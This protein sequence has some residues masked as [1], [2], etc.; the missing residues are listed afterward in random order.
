M[1]SSNSS[2]WHRTYLIQYTIYIFSTVNL[3]FLAQHI[4][5]VALKSH[6][7]TTLYFQVASIY[8]SPT[9]G[10][11]I[12]IEIVKMEILHN[13]RV[14]KSIIMYEVTIRYLKAYFYFSL[15]F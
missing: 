10:N 7:F 15:R 14:S 11:A 2:L 9:V 8:R 1:S 6:Y 4:I 5:N 13:D 3:L 12:S